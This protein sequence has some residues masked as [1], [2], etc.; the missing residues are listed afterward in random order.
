MNVFPIKLLSCA[1]GQYLMADLKNGSTI[2]GTLIEID[3]FMNLKIENAVITSKDGDK[4]HKA[5]EYF[6]RGNAIKY[7]RLPD[8]ALT[9]ATSLIK[10]KIKAAKA[11]N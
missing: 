1:E 3:R 10:K 11:K 9:K 7:I 8:A 6:I 5:Q 2:N 4:F